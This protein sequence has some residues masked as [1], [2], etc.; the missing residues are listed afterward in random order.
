M[1]EIQKVCGHSIQLRCIRSLTSRA[2]ARAERPY[3]ELDRVAEIWSE[4]HGRLGLGA[5]RVDSAHAHLHAIEMQL[6]K[7]PRD[8]LRR[9]L[10]HL[11]LLC[12]VMR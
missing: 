9:M 10:L 6:H 8:Q 5:P 1:P 2:A 7:I 11:P 3:F 12:E 4:L